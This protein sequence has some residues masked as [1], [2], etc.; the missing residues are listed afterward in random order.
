MYTFAQA[1]ED[2]F[3]QGKAQGRARGEA[4]GRPQGEARAARQLLLQFAAEVWGD[5]EAE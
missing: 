5:A 4:D 1:L 3:K 2:R